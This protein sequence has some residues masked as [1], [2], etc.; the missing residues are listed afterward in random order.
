MTQ[1]PLTF[2]VVLSALNLVI[3]MYVY[4]RDPQR[5]VNRVFAA[6]S[7]ATSVWGVAIGLAYNSPVANL[8]F[9]RCTFAA[10]SL[11]LVLLPT[12]FSVFPSSPFP[13]TYVYY[14]F[15]A[16]GLTFTVLSFT[17]SLVGDLSRVS[18]TITLSY[19]NA[20]RLFG[21]Y[22]FASLGYCIFLLWRKITAAVGFEKLQLR[23]LLLALLLPGIGI[24]ITNLLIPL[25]S[26]DSR[27]G[28]YGPAFILIFLGLTAHAIIRHR[29]MNIRLVIS[30][31][32]AYLLAVIVSAAA[33]ALLIEV[34]SFVFGY[35]VL[36]LPLGWEVALILPIAVLFQPISRLLRNALDRYFYRTPYNYERTIRDVS[37]TIGTMLDLR[38][39]L[40]YVCDV[41]G[42]TVHPEHIGVYMKPPEGSAGYHLMAHRNFLSMPTATLP[43]STPV[44]SALGR[45]F[46]SQRGPLLREDAM[47]FPQPLRSA[48]LDDVTTLAAE[49]VHPMFD[50][51]HPSGFIVLGR[52]LSG[53]PYFAEDLSLLTTLV[54][55]AAVAIKNAYLHRHVVLVNEYVENILAAMD[56][57][58]VAVA[59]DGTVTLF[60]TAAERLTGLQGERIKTLPLANLPAPLAQI[61]RLTLT[62]GQPQLQRE[63]FLADANRKWCPVVC[64]TSTLTSRSATNLGAVAVLSDL[65]RLKELE[66]E[67]LRADR[68]ASIGALA[69]GIAHEIKNPLVAIRTFAELLPD[70]FAQADFRDDFAKVVI[71]EIHRIDG[72]ASRLLGMASPRPQ[73]LQP[74]NLRES[75][76]DTLALLRWRLE[77]GGITVQTEFELERPMVDG[78]ADQLK[79]LFLNLVVNAIE[80]MGQGG[81]LTVR[82]TQR[83]SAGVPHLVVEVTDNGTGIPESLADRL[84]E[85]FVTTKE[86]G[87]GLGLSIC[88]GIAEAHGATIHAHNNAGGRGA[89]LVVEFP[90]HAIDAPIPRG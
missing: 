34:A 45:Y 77:Q 22:A 86:N 8:L 58:V 83:D 35:R 1:P 75:L 66:A 48:V 90:M 89:T 52:K 84:F 29:L 6:H 10:A 73:P 14:S 43:E 32:A 24:T 70:R 62:T 16:I 46:I 20:H 81:Q 25:L 5:L 80:A 50:D 64:S 47:R 71:H 85:P 30:R 44:S 60:N 78:D 63:F 88:R 49:C 40:D 13:R 26:G 7:A 54:T 38:P 2:Y 15:A 28:R 41:V 65:S 39:L 36:E 59:A 27:F 23:Y 67:K 18:Q 21:G 42:R 55:Q 82:V 11:M 19:G 33:L 31:G 9:A 4:V 72:L 37:Q 69:S 3:G 12:L 79:Q 17:T 68:L 76:S 87:S 74:V 56:S 57:G 53:D 51:G 61:L